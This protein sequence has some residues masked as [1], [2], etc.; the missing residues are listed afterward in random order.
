MFVAAL[1]AVLVWGTLAFGSVYPWAYQ[2][3]I[4][5]CAVC[6]VYGLIVARRREWRE[7]SLL[8]ALLFLALVPAVQLVPMSSSALQSISP[9]AD[10]F[11]RGQDLSY[12]LSP[13]AHPLSINPRATMR[14][15]MLLAGFGVLLLGLVRALRASTAQRLGLCLIALGVVVA[16]IG[17]V[18]KATLGDHAFAGMKIYGIWEPE[19]KLTTPFGPFVNKNH[20]AGWMLMV[21][22]LAV[23][24][25]FE[26]MERATH[27][28]RGARSTLIWLSSPDGGRFQ[29]LIFA[30]TLMAVSVL[31]TGSRSGLGGLIFI[32]VTAI[33]FASRRLQSTKVRWGVLASAAALF[34]IVFLWAG[35]D[36]AARVGQ[37]VNAVELRKRI[38]HDTL[39]I[40][41]DFPV[42][43]TG[44]NTF[45]T[46]TV[47]YQSSNRDV[48]YQEAH[49]EYLQLA[50]EGG[51]LLIVAAIVLLTVIARKIRRRFVSGRDGPAGYWLRLGAV[52]G[53]VA[54]ALQSIVEFSLQMP[55]NAAL[56]VVVLALCL[57][58]PGP[59]PR[60]S[61]EEYSA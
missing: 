56:F 6:G 22:P 37:R 55:G 41:R 53:V 43:G 60:T 49:N 27:H 33:F 23:C 32:V 10:R 59:R 26:V 3:L 17:I 14:G 13:A 58:R 5:A 15:L 30:A 47:A 7:R 16:L 40:V 51:V 25:A 18:Q 42:A 46:A 21:F 36:V 11:L 2:P 35:A 57:H 20:F 1:V 28:R 34:V 39:T 24:L 54:I 31:M 45:G 8:L 44:L 9:A 52:I 12:A 48:H 61:L 50:A 19:S 4:A 29:L 38:W